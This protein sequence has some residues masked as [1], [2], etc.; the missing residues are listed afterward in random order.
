M[1]PAGALH[2]AVRVR[3]AEPQRLRHLTWRLAPDVD[4]QRRTPPRTRGRI[5]GGPHGHAGRNDR[6]G[7]DR[8]TE[9]DHLVPHR[10]RSR[11]GSPALGELL[12][13]RRDV[14]HRLRRSLSPPA[15]R[16]RLGRPHPGWPGRE[17]F[18]SGRLPRRRRDPRGQDRGGVTDVARPHACRPGD[19][20]DRQ[21]R[22][23]GLRRHPHAPRPTPPAARWREPR[24]PGGDD[25]PRWAGRKCT[26]AARRVPGLRS[27]PRARAQR[28]VH[29]RAQ[30]GEARRPGPGRPRPHSHRA[31]SHG[32]DGR[33]GDDGRRLGTL[34]GVEVSARRLFRAAGDRRTV[35]R[36]RTA[37]R[38][39]HLAPA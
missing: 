5:R 35:T 4:G 38:L 18:R 24:S 34:H 1:C 12:G 14:D 13:R 2:H 19:R 30:Y 10:R 28:R 6:C 29:G 15:E 32:G 22:H 39:L 9:P 37:R 36:R 21:A 33:R 8:H 20:R 11:P 31:A 23:P 17:R 7:R 25:R 26:L 16:R 27:I 3:R